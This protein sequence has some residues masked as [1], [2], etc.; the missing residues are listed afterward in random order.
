[1]EFGK[2]GPG[3]DLKTGKQIMLIKLRRVLL[4]I[5]QVYEKYKI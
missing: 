4:N 1:M 5:I 3:L 2:L